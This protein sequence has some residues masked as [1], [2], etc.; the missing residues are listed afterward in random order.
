MDIYEKKLSKQKIRK[1]IHLAKTFAINND[2]H[3]AARLK[4]IS[5]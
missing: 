2:K 5:H 4:M 3:P 1:Y